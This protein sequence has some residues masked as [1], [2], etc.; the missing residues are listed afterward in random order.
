MH[1]PSHFMVVKRPPRLV[2]DS[3]PRRPAATRVEVTSVDEDRL[4][5]ASQRDKH[6]DVT[7]DFDATVAKS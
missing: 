5:P 7:A 2:D 4:E 1:D 6:V 3:P